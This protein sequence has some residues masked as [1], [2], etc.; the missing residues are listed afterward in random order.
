MSP[1]EKATAPRGRGAGAD[2]ERN[3]SAESYRHET[4]MRQMADRVRAL[5]RREHWWIAAV[6]SGRPCCPMC[7]RQEWA[8]EWSA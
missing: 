8:E 2:T 6:K 3:Q 7:R 5:E 4:V 1:P